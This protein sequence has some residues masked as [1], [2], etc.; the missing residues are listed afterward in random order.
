[1]VGAPW[2]FQS[3]SNAGFV[4]N[5]QALSAP[6]AAIPPAKLPAITAA[7]LAKCDG[8]DGLVD[9]V[10][11][12]PAQ[13]KFNP[14]VLACNGAETN[15]CLTQPQL[16]ALKKIYAGPSNPRTGKKIFPGFTVGSEL[17][18]TG[19]VTNLTASGLGNGYFA[20]LTFE[21]PNWDYRTF[22]FDQDMAFADRKVGRLGNAIET[23]LSPAKRRG[24][25]LIQYH[26]WNDQ[27]LQP[28]YSP[29]YY[30]SVAKEM[31]GLRKTQDFY[32]LF[33]VPGMTHCYFGPGATS[34]GAVGQQLPPVRDSKHD[35]QKALEAWV[36][37]GIAPERI[38]ATKY[39]DDAAATRTILLQRPLCP[40]P[41]VAHYTGRGDANDAKNFVCR[42]EDRDDDD[43]H[44]H[45]HGKGHGH[46]H[47]HGGG[48]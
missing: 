43:D 8:A 14:D 37:R 9:G 33:M 35:I 21:D 11:A 5:A 7:V 45:G 22:D 44:G 15:A 32:R 3:H 47:G 4:W 10:I 28:P 25:K 16:G 31:G 20:N 48:H 13:C 23:D 17:A 18:W 42:G 2:N 34:F 40:Y 1:V 38:I 39:T 6:G 27:T 41:Q 46:G 19:L 36:E 30:E 26:G 29:Q 24:V 12:N